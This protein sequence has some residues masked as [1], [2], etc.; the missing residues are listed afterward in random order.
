M[1]IRAF[2]KGLAPM[3]LFFAIGCNPSGPLVYT[4]QPY[5]L[6]GGCVGDYVPVGVV[7]GTSLGGNCD[8]MCMTI[9]G[10]LYVSTACPPLPPE[11]VAASDSPDCAQALSAAD[12]GLFCGDQ[13]DSDAEAGDEGGAAP[14]VSNYHR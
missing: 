8:P 12:A 6:E 2:L 14:D 13:T 7:Y 3:A 1:Q 5:S 4:A 11:A 10:Q 9:N